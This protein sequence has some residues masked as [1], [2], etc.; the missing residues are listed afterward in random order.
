MEQWRLCGL[1]DIENLRLRLLGQNVVSDSQ[2]SNPTVTES[3]PSN[4]VNDCPE[5]TAVVAPTEKEMC[6]PTVS[7]PVSQA[8]EKPYYTPPS[9]PVP[10]DTQNNGAPENHN[11][12][13]KEGDQNE[14]RI[15]LSDL[16][17]QFI[18]LS[19]ITFGKR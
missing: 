10:T 4:R 8:T 1:G 17:K 6:S 11:S 3:Q 12:L 18:S 2:D 9:T 19:E 16:A 7:E 14:T 5:E 13:A 15:E